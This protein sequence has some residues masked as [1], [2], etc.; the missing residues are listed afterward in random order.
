MLIELATGRKR[1]L[2]SLSRRLPVGIFEP[3]LDR[4]VDETVVDIERIC[5]VKKRVV[6][7]C[8]ADLGILLGDLVLDPNS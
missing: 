5:V 6:D 1:Q 2:E 7:T 4:F 3:R 8:S